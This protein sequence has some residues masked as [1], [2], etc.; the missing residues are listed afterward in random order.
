VREAI[1]LDTVLRLLGKQRKDEIDA[2]DW[3]EEHRSRNVDILIEAV[4]R[5]SID[6]MYVKLKYSLSAPEP[7]QKSSRPGKS[8]FHPRGCFLEVQ[9]TS[10]ERSGDM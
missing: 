1:F 6:Q 8:P 2:G 9:E 4:T 7:Y 5:P 10:S 3:L